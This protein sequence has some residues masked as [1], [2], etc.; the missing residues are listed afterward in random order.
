MAKIK[1]DVKMSRAERKHFK[2]S[3]LNMEVQK[4]NKQKKTKGAKK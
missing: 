4:K 2:Y 1:S 3:K